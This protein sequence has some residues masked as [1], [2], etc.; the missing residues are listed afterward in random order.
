MRKNKLKI[1]Q[2][3]LGSMGKRRIRNLLFHE[4]K[5]SQIIGFDLAAPRRKEME[6]LFPEIKTYGD[7]NLAMKNESPNVF[8]ISTPPNLHHDYF[9]F[10]AKNKINFFCEVP[11]NDKGYKELMPKLSNKFVAAPSCTFRYVPAIKKIKELLGNGIIG[12][13]LIFNHYLGQYLPD[14]HP[15]EDYRKVYFAK[16]ETGGA[17]EMLPYELVWLSHIF[18]SE[19]KKA[20]GACRKVSDL[21]MTA[22]DVYSVIVQFENGVLGN[23]MID[24]LNREAGRTLRI[25]GTQGTLDWDWLGYSIRIKQAGVK[26]AKL[27]NVKKEKKFKHYNTTEDIYREEMKKFLDAVCG[28]KKYPYSY[29]EDYRI[30]KVYGA[31]EKGNNLKEL[32]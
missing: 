21:E 27:I 1:L 30:L 25:I 29:K 23:M 12:K 3:G 2:I 32:D 28:K 5:E 18:K 14:W 26:T 31:V 6:K 7:F 19:P 20:T 15:Y 13:P 17:K 16:K 10:A 11:T 24:L 8:I 4:I 9:L 22:D